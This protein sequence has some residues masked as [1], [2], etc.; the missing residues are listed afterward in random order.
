MGRC[1]R[2]R[3]ILAFVILFATF[4]HVVPPQ[5]A[6]LRLPAFVSATIFT[7][8]VVSAKSGAANG[9]QTAEIRIRHRQLHFTGPTGVESAGLSGLVK[10]HRIVLT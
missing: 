10:Q 5:V 3:P 7:S 9:P 4:N 2:Q 6:N 1:Y 8:D